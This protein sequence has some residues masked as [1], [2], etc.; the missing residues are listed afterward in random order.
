M[1][2]QSP[3]GP[4]HL[5][6]RFRLHHV[7]FLEQGFQSH[8]ATPTS[9]HVSVV[10]LGELS[11][12]YESQLNQKTLVAALAILHI[13]LVQDFQR[14]VKEWQRAFLSLLLV[15]GSLALAHFKKAKRLLVFCHHHVA[16]VRGKTI[17]DIASIEAALN[18]AVEQHHY[19]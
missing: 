18:D 12:A 4:S 13:T 9:R 3:C 17:D 14:L 8:R 1:R 19:V 10:W 5:Y 16:H 7:V 11:H 6:G 15:F 2:H